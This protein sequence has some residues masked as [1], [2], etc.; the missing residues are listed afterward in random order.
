MGLNKKKIILNGFHLF[1]INKRKPKFNRKAFFFTFIAIV[2]LSIFIVV[3]SYKSEVPYD[4]FESEKP[5]IKVVNAFIKD[6]EEVFLTRVLYTSGSIVLDSFE[7]ETEKNG[8]VDDVEL[9]AESLL[10]L[11]RWPSGTYELKMENHTLLNWSEKLI[12]L[13][14]DEFKI[15]LNLTFHEVRVRQYS[16]WLLSFETDVTIMVNYSEISYIIRDE[17]SINLS[18]IDRRDPLFIQLDH[19]LNVD[20]DRIIKKIDINEWNSSTI[21]DHINNQT[22]EYSNYAPSYI[23][24]MEN[25]SEFSSC[26]GIESFMNSSYV[27]NYS[28]VDHQFFNQ[29]NW[30]PNQL[31]N[32]TDV[33]DDVSGDG[34]QFKLDLLHLAQYGYT[35]GDGKTDNVICS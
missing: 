10:L 19:F 23:L 3:F 28:Y 25:S 9:A 16:P 14:W 18:I 30:C 31:F 34:E 27:Q 11:G 1:C 21:I 15:K 26:C 32:L 22:F 2:I 13:A 35:L 17:I 24:R 6:V 29:T 12:D 4:N 7:N 5:Q 33:W 20:N 8:K